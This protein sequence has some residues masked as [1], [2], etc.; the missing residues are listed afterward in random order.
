[1][2]YFLKEAEVLGEQTL[3]KKERF[4][5]LL[6]QLELTSDQVVSYFD[7]ASI[8]KVVINKEQK[9]WHFYFHF[10]QVLPF[11][12]YE[13]FQARIQSAFSHIANVS[14][15]IVAETKNCTQDDIQSYWQHCISEL[16]GISP[17]LMS[18]LQGQKPTLNGVKLVL[19]ARHEAEGTALRK[20]YGQ[21]IADQYASYG[22]PQ[23][24]LVT[25]VV[26]SEEAF[27]QFVEQRKQEDTEKVL[28]AITEMQ[29]KENEKSD[30]PDVPKGPLTI[31]YT[32]KDEVVSL[33]TIVDEEK[34]I[35]VQG[36]VFDAE[37][38]ELRSGRTLLIFKITDY[39]NSIM[40]KM[41][42][43]DKEDIPLLQAI[44]K[45]M[46]V[47]VRGSVQ[48]D[49]FVRDLVMIGNDV[50]EI[51]PITR[52][53]KASDDEKRVEL[54]LHTPMSQMDAVT[55]VST[56]VGQAKK[57][58]HKAI[59]VTDHAVAQS[60]PEAY[61]A[62]KKN[63]IKILYG[64]EANLVD[65]GVPIAYNPQDVALPDA[66][67]IVFD[68][69]TT[70]LSAVYDTVIELAAV[71]MKEGEIIDKFESFANPHHPLSATTIELTG[72][73]D[74]MVQDAPDASEVLKKFSDWIGNDIL[75]AHNASFDMGFLNAG[76]QRAGFEKVQNG[77]IDTL[78]LARF[79]YPHMKNHRLNTLAKK[80]DIELVQHHRAIYDAETT[81]YLLA[82]MLKDAFERDILNH[83]QLNDYMGEGNAYQRARPYH[84]TML[85]QNETGLKNLFKLISM[86]HLNYFYRVPRIPRSKLQKFR[87]GILIGTACDR[88][89]VFEGMMQKGIDEVQEAAEFYD[90]IEVQPPENY[91]HLIE[92]ELVRDERA[93]KDIINNIVKL[94]EKLDK[95][96]VATGNVHYLNPEDKIYRKILISSQ[97]GANPL[98]RHQLPDVH[99]RTTD[100]MLECFSFL[101][102][103]KAKEIVVTNTQKI[104]DMIE[105]VKPIK[106]DLYTPKIEGADEEMR[107]MSYAMARSIYGDDLPEVVEARLEKEL[108]SIIGHGFAVIY[109]ISHKLVKKSLDDGYLVGSRGSVGSSFVATMTE[110]TEVNPL[111]PHYVCPSCKH[112]EFFD[113]GSVGSG[114]DL[115]DKSC[116]ECGTPYKKDGHDI[117]FETFLGFKGDKVPDIDLNFSGEYQPRAHNYTK[118]LFGEDN[119]YRAGTIGTVAEKTA[120][121]YV[122]GY[123][124]DHELH[125]RNAEVDRLVAGCTGVKRTTGQHPGGIIVVP[126]YMDIYDFTP[127]Q[128]PADDRNSE[129]RTTH[130]DF[131]SIHDNLLKLDILGHDDPTVIRMLQDLSGIDPKTIPTDDPEVMKIFSGTESLGVT[132]EQIMCK[133]GTLGIPEFGT[134]FVRQMLEDTKPS[135]FSEL[136][137]ISGLSHGTDVWL[138]NAQELIRNNICNLSE[139]IGCRDDIMV[140]LIYQGLEPSLAFKIMESVR[141]GKGLSPEFEEEMIK[142]GVPDWYIDSCKK[143]KY[144]FPKAHAAAYVLMAVRIAYFKVHHALLYYAAYFTVRADDFDIDTMIKGSTAIKSKM[145]EINGKGLDA[146]PKEKNLLT[147]LELALE[148]CERG[149]S[150]K[151]VDLYESSADEFIID[152]TSLI[153]PFNSIPGLGTNAALN[154]VKARKDGEFLSKEDLQQRG[155]VSKTILEYLDNHG[156]LESLPDQNQLSLF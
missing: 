17:L 93:L 50:N 70:G 4:K 12:V 151:K 90:Y 24:Q 10:Q 49:T 155:K 97:G 13:L 76:L 125:L 74:D 16:Q 82:K 141:K 3:G 25:E 137:Q 135:T 35:A 21:L 34:R 8:E 68:V 87:D 120:Y 53:D 2:H 112:S 143:I 54:H 66:T 58:G 39:T 127:I 57:W 72:I 59:A 153:P 89:E 114:F 65:D 28:Q 130:F 60:F 80:F 142:N 7:Q 1:M 101:D 85:A 43:R 133:T 88:G 136:V 154:I 22:F 29:N 55:S 26:H 132:E 123:A 134:R 11:N 110:I 56:L 131:H 64:V 95:P 71:K 116:V 62:G 118:V 23:M 18:L 61:G 47:K 67:Y 94:G 92:L 148:M 32:I 19:N 109:L 138:G 83:N 111:P 9:K 78:E 63:G 91:K 45:G 140:Y 6:Q 100:E 86:S 52:Q 108:K 121:G 99:F 124:G 98:N 122:K 14:F 41:F 119:V 129:W 75:V 147:V 144:M 77:V 79:L 102:A 152:G 5:L 139:V 105:E 30:G 103:N 128:F 149:Y 36:Y 42:S 115:P 106:D 51:S 81:G 31:G 40:I 113:D 156:C 150:F 96:V 146:S 73:T 48:N 37:T 145:E 104:A 69:E 84:V 27:Q 126:D 117:P 107:A 46:W 44:K 15:S 38:R 20:K 33:D